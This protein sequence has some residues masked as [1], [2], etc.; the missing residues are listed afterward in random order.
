MKE[1][2]LKR[3]LPLALAGVAVLLL[4]GTASCVP[5]QSVVYQPVPVYQIQAS[6][7]AVVTNQVNVPY[8]VY[9]PV[10]RTHPH[11]W[12]VPQPWPHPVPGPVPH[13]G[14]SPVPGPHPWP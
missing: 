10:P 13:P 3:G 4:I 5:A 2:L 8:P 6:Q 1:N 11:P 12:P 14:P 9:V 7:P